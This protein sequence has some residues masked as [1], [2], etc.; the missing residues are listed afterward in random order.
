MDIKCDAVL[1]TNITEIIDCGASIL[2]ITVIKAILTLVI[3]YPVI[4]FVTAQI[5]RLFDRVDLD[6]TVEMFITACQETNEI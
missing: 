3:G 2:E 1:G 5:A 4:I 6:E